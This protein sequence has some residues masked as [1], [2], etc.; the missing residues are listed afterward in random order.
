MKS[1]LW[2]LSFLDLFYQKGCRGAGG[3]DK[4]PRYANAVCVLVSRETDK[5]SQSIDSL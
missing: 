3:G 2:G 1:E 5:E 4:A